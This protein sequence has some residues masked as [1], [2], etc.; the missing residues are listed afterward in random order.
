KDFSKI[1]KPLT[2]LL[3][4]DIP[5]NF[6][7]PCL[8]AFLMLKEKLIN[9]L[10][11]IAPDWNLDFEIICDASDSAVGA[12]LGQRKDKYIQP[13]YYASKTLNAAQE[14]YTTTEKELLV[15]VFSFNK[16]RSYLILSKVIVYTDQ[17]VLKYLL[18]KS[19]AKLRLI[20]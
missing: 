13:M 6:S 14:N 20:R 15:V 17:S 5:F 2:D 19:D 7:K 10:I 8:K 11:M 16:L 1:A 12:V 3:Q 9:A 18:S 4:K